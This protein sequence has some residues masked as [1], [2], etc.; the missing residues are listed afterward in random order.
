[1]PKYESLWNSR[2]EIGL[3]RASMTHR[4]HVC[5][6]MEQILENAQI[7]ILTLKASLV[8][9]NVLVSYPVTWNLMQ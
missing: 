2:F 7:H 5:G 8:Q 6:V 3:P 1:M 4:R 9:T